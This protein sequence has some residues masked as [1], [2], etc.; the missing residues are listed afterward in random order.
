MQQDSIL[1]YEDL[2]NTLQ[3][4]DQS[5]FLHHSKNSKPQST[6]QFD[7]PLAYKNT[8]PQLSEL[9]ELAQSLRQNKIK[10]KNQPIEHSDEEIDSFAFRK[11]R[12]LNI[13]PQKP[14]QLQKNAFDIPYT[15]PIKQN[16]PIKQTKYIN[17][18]QYQD[19]P[20]M[21]QKQT[22]NED[23]QE[24]D[25][26]KITSPL[27]RAPRKF[28][29]PLK[30][31]STL[32]NAVELPQESFIEQLALST[33]KSPKQFVFQQKY[34]AQLNSVHEKQHKKQ[35]EDIEIHSCKINK[36]KSKTQTYSSKQN[37]EDSEP[38]VEI[39]TEDDALVHS[40]SKTII[41]PKQ[42]SKTNQS[43]SEQ[44]TKDLSKIS[45]NDE[46]NQII[47]ISLKR[48]Q[49]KTV[50][51]QQ[52]ESLDQ[53]SSSEL[54]TKRTIPQNYKQQSNEEYEFEV[55]EQTIKRSQKIKQCKQYTDNESSESNQIQIS[56]NQ[57][58]KTNQ[59]QLNSQST[60][61]IKQ[62]TQL[63]QANNQLIR[64]TGQIQNLNEKQIIEIKT[65][66]AKNISEQFYRDMYDDDRYSK[67]CI[68]NMETV[69]NQTD[70]TMKNKDI[71]VF[72]RQLIPKYTSNQNINAID[73]IHEVRPQTHK[74]K[75]LQEESDQ[76]IDINRIR[77][78]Y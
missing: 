29:K 2:Y 8:P 68:L 31:D 63:V 25:V 52:S 41:K 66:T 44:D 62:N 48:S 36:P 56:R 13:N 77:G 10:P 23:E 65:E 6:N 12:N 38:S 21:K 39:F 54:N 45:Q 67:P 32:F 24:L 18:K 51:K 28:K 33:D 7:V 9:E 78:G 5:S 46:Q 60:K 1:S 53:S 55:Q 75:Y 76:Y 14:A 4:A 57:K 3:S 43:Y 20:K 11:K 70:I 30:H 26:Q 59:K 17:Q 15:K 35:E 69:N 34:S 72:K 58:S 49:K 71:P 64:S 16:T 19:K 74:R 73:E 61:N 50:S 40:C 22:I 47:Q 42:F 37:I 27:I